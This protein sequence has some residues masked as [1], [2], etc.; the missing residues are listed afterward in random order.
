MGVPVFLQGVYADF[1]LLGNIRMEDL[2]YKVAL[3]W[4]V[5]EVIFYGELAAED[6]SLIGSADGALDFSLNVSSIGFIYYD[7]DT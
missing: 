4:V 2:G 6:A 1:A 3:G 7:S 5:G